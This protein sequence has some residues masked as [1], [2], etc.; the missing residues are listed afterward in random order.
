MN[1]CWLGRCVRDK[2]SG[3]LGTVTADLPE[4]EH[5]ALAVEFGPGQW[6]SYHPNLW[7]KEHLFELVPHERHD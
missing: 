4:P 5:D 1:D 7:S 2:R 6:H 3:L